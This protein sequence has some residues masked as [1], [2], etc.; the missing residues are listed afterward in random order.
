LVLG[1]LYNSGLIWYFEAPLKPIVEGMLGLPAV[2]GLTLIFAVL[3]KELAL[4]FLMALAAQK[5]GL[6]NSGG[7]ASMLSFMTKGQIYVFALV[8]TL[9]IPCIAT[10]AALMKEIGIKKTIYVTILTIITAILVGT[11]ARIVIGAIIQ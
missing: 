8:N 5:M 9:Y 1:Y 4:V 3:R 6:N 2:A 7:G 11:I 10:L